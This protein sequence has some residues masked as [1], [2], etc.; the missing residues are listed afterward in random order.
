MDWRLSLKITAI[1]NLII[2]SSKKRFDCIHSI[3]F[4]LI[5]IEWLNFLNAMLFKLNQFYLKEIENDS[6]QS[7]KIENVF[8]PRPQKDK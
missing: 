6:W 3:I 8:D 1:R 2:L 5:E 7:L 4:N